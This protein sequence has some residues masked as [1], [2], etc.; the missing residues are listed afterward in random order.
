MR[1]ASRLK[2][3]SAQRDA[4]LR[5]AARCFLA[6]LTLALVMT[7]LMIVTAMT[8]Q[9]QG[10]PADA[11]RYRLTLKREA[12]AVWGL[13]AP[14]ASL[15]GQI[16]QE[17]RWNPD[18]KSPVGA[19]GLAQFMPSTSNWI[20]GLYPSL[21]ERSPSNPTW[22]IRALVTYDAHL[23]VRVRADNDCE[24]FAFALSAYNGGLGWVYKRQALSRTP[25]TCLSATCLINPGITPAA[26]AENAAYPRVILQRHQDLYALWGPRICP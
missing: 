11:A 20:S 5:R 17:S 22:A 3:Y 26:Q 10:V 2:A 24:R 18:A 8:A 15:A 6:V 12:Q 13:N 7:V 23:F 4:G 1:E 25:G 9:A 21:A 19:Q 14:V 16:H